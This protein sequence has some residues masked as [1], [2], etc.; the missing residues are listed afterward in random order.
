MNSKFLRSMRH[1]LWLL[2]GVNLLLFCTPVLV[3]ATAWTYFFVGAGVSICFYV[4]CFTANDD[5]PTSANLR[6]ILTS[7]FVIPLGIIFFCNIALRLF[8]LVALYH[9][10]PQILL[11][12]VLG[13]YYFIPSPMGIAYII[14]TIAFLGFA[15]YRKVFRHYKWTLSLYT[16]VVLIYVLYILWWHFTD[17]KWGYL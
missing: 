3:Y 8:A 17:Q 16:V 1:L 12:P 4:A 15:F 13:A 10:V 9:K 6:L 14:V 2:T 7:I 11:V 5:R